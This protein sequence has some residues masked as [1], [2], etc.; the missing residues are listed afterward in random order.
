[1]DFLPEYI[2]NEALLEALQRSFCK[3][4]LVKFAPILGE[5]QKKSEITY[6]NYYNVF[7][8]LLAVE[9]ITQMDEYAKLI[10]I[11]EKVRPHTIY[12]PNPKKRPNKYCIKMT[13][14]NEA[15]LS[16]DMD[17]IV[18]V[19][20]TGLP[21]SPLPTLRVMALFHG[22][23]VET[24][25][26]ITPKLIIFPWSDER[27][28][29][30]KELPNKLFDIIFRSPRVP[31]RLMYLTLELFVKNDQLR[32][33]IFPI[34]DVRGKQQLN[35]IEAKPTVNLTLFNESINGNPEQLQAVQQIVMGPNPRAPYIVFGPP[36]KKPR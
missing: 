32:R 8:A 19:D 24:I 34:P 33:Y 30:Q 7:R 12:D 15:L 29:N 27:F 11:N 25:S 14:K 36:G 18:F 31:V 6:E 17:E 3:E 4:S 26:K 1:M 13:G 23:H 21:K 5:Y 16:A 10:Q 28:I 35:K 22:G 9:D 20:R 2:P